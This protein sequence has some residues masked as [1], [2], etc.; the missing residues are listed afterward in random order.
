MELIRRRRIEDHGSL[1][2]MEMCDGGISSL[3]VSRQLEVA[4]LCGLSDAAFTTEV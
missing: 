4:K 2:E 3:D 1:C